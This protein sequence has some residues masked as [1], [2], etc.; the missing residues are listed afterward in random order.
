MAELN[1]YLCLPPAVAPTIQTT[2]KVRLTFT[3]VIKFTQ[4]AIK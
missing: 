3:L 1:R 4:N 2:S